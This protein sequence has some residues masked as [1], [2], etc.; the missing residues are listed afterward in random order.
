[1]MKGIQ[2]TK[3]SKRTNLLYCF[4]LMRNALQGLLCPPPPS[5]YA[6]YAPVRRR[7][8]PRSGIAMVGMGDN[9]CIKKD[10]RQI[11]SRSAAAMIRPCCGGATRRKRLY[12]FGMHG[13]APA[14]TLAMP[15]R[16]NQHHTHW[17]RNTVAMGLRVSVMTGDVRHDW[18]CQD[19]GL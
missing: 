8:L 9:P 12:N 10:H 2:K 14:P 3:R 11:A 1:M 15:L 4:M 13:L 7:D 6:I 17:Q 19:T 16:G 18:G 5:K